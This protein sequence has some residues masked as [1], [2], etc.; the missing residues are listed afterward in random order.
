MGVKIVC[1]P[2][3]AISWLALTGNSR[4]RISFCKNIKFSK[5]VCWVVS[6]LCLVRKSRYGDNEGSPYSVKRDILG[7][8]WKAAVQI[9]NL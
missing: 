1:S 7:E 5:L 8:D 3:E 2:L 4:R 6:V 9:C